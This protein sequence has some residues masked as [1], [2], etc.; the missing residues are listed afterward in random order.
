MSSCLLEKERA[1]RIGQLSKS[2]DLASS[3]ARS[4]MPK[5]K[6]GRANL[7]KVLAGG[8]TILPPTTINRQFV[9]VVFLLFFFFFFNLFFYFFALFFLQSSNIFCSFSSHLFLPTIIIF[10]YK[11]SLTKTYSK[12]TYLRGQGSLC[13]LFTPISTT[14]WKTE[15]Q[16]WR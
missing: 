6:D 11:D 12:G 4:F 10:S 7:L 14:S 13:T 9:V 8:C 1:K 15:V 2:L 5:V 16:A 3:E